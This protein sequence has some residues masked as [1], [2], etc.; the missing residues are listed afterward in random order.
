MEEKIGR[1]ALLE[2]IKLQISILDKYKELLDSPERDEAKDKL[3]D[4]I[5]AAI[6]AVGPVLALQ[7]SAYSKAVDL[8]QDAV[9]QTQDLLE[10]LK[11]EEEER[12]NIHKTMRQ[13]AEKTIRQQAERGGRRK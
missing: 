3:N 12:A 2:L 5:K 8:H 13:Q 10:E 1:E 4:V 6:K 7:Y 9:K 11:K